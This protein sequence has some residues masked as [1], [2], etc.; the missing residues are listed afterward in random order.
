MTNR[1]IG[2]AAGAKYSKYLSE[3]KNK[4]YKKN[5]KRS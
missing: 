3:K 1:T 5:N 2:S 4:N